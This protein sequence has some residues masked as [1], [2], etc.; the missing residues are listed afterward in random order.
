MGR[1]LCHNCFVNNYRFEY[2]VK[3]LSRTKRKDYENYVINAVWNRLHDNTIK[4]ASQWYVKNDAGWHLIDLYFP[5]INF[6]VECDEGHHKSNIENDEQRELTLIE[7]LSSVNKHPYQA[8]HI[9]VTLPFD[10]IEARI[11]QCVDR[12]RKIVAER[13]ESGDFVQWT[14]I[15]LAEYFKSQQIIRSKDDILFPTIAN[16]VNNLM[17]L[18]KKSYQQGYFTPQGLDPQYKFWF[19]QL[20]INGQAQAFG[21]HNILSDDGKMITEYN[22]DVKKNLPTWE[23]RGTKEFLDYTRVVFAK[24]QDPITNKRAYK[25]VGVFN[26]KE[27]SNKDV[28]TYIKVNDVF[29]A[30]KHKLATRY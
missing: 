12:I 5:Q 10:E 2:L 9:D 16:V 8:F 20:E 22:D 6:G 25:F 28:R 14:D 24:V 29:D 30:S 27:I 4:P 21:W 15:D 11:T 7:V 3:T 23:Y 18:N 13:R 19:P 1:L 26:L 17:Q